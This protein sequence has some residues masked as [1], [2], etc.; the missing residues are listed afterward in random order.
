MKFSS[1]WPIAPELGTLQRSM[2]RSETADLGVED[3]S[4]GETGLTLLRV[5]PSLLDS[6]PE[7]HLVQATCA[8]PVD[9]E[10]LV[11]TEQ[12]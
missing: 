2:R 12:H 3:G 1:A 10:G 9:K 11:C 4:C 7:E 5:L 8:S 6:V